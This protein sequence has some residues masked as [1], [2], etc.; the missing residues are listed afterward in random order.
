MEPLLDGEYTRGRIL[1]VIFVV[2]LRAIGGGQERLPFHAV[3]VPVL[4]L[5]EKAIVV[6][7]V[8]VVV[9]VGDSIPQ[10]VAILLLLLLLLL[11]LFVDRGYE[12]SPPHISC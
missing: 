8:V 10:I 12:E 11:L 1:P 6:V 3:D 4:P 7:V 5:R 9:A 2:V